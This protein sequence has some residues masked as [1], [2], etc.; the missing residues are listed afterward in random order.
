[1]S[2]PPRVFFTLTEAAAR[3]GCSPADIGGWAAVGRIEI[4]TGI[5]PITCGTERIA[6]L[7]IVA[8][9]DLLPMF[10]RCGS[11]PGEFLVRRVREAGSDEWR[12][13]TEPQ[14]GLLVDKAD[15][16][17][18][19]DEVTRFEDEFGI[20]KRVGGG[21]GP[22]PKYDWDG[23]YLQ[24]IV[25]IHESGL[26][27]TQGELVGHMQEWFIAKSA[28]GDVPDESTIRRRISPIWRALRDRA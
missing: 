19:A 14:G 18:M 3:W 8:A 28:D 10:R 16:M 11:G 26:P 1:M 24:V 9:S 25:R 23:F 7:V 20:F 12:Y 5:P 2:L 15:L 21:A 27:E 6:G 13:I 22:A 4:V 17:I